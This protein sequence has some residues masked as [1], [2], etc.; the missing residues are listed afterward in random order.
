MKTWCWMQ[1][2]EASLLG[3]CQV[4]PGNPG[5]KTGILKESVNRWPACPWEASSQQ[6]NGKNLAWHLRKL[7]WVLSGLSWLQKVGV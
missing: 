6:V 1:T 4:T 2:P 3:L 5:S 7:L